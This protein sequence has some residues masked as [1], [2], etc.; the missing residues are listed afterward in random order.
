MNISVNPSDNPVIYWTLRFYKYFLFIPFTILLYQVL[1][2]IEA[3]FIF[4][5]NISKVQGY[6]VERL[7]GKSG[8]NWKCS[9]VENKWGGKSLNIMG[10]GQTSTFWLWMNTVT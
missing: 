10:L 2:Y 6:K 3:I 9:L 1:Y 8:T 4:K 5:I 7:K